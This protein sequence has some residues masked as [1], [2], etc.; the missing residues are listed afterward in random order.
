[1][2]RFILF[3]ISF[4]LALYVSAQ[5]TQTAKYDFVHP[6][7]LT[8]AIVMGDIYEIQVADKTFTVGPISLRLTSS[9]LKC[10]IRNT[11]EGCFLMIPRGTTITIKGNKVKLKSFS[12]G[13]K[14]QSGGLGL[15]K[16]QPGT[17]RFGEWSCDGKDDVT[18]VSLTNTSASDCII[19]T[20]DV[21]YVTPVDGLEPLTVSPADKATVITNEFNGVTFSFGTNISSADKEAFTFK[22]ITTGASIGA[23][24]AV[25]GKN[26]TVSPLE[27]L[28]A[29][30]YT[31]DV[32]SK[33]FKTA[34]GMYNKAFTTSFT[35]IDPQNMFNPTVVPD[36][37]V[38]K[39]PASFAI[40]FPSE[41]GNKGNSADPKDISKISVP[42]M[43][44]VTG[45]E[46][47]KASFS[48][49]S[50]EKNVLTVTLNP[51]TDITTNG[52]YK[53]SIPEKSVYNEHYGK[54]AVE[55]EL[56]NSEI[57]IEFQVGDVYVASEEILSE[58]SKALALSGLGYPSADAA[59][60]VALKK[61]YNEAKNE[62]KGSDDI[63]TA[64]INAF[65]ASKTVEM[66]LADNYY[67]LANMAK[68][69]TLRYLQYA[70]GKVT[71]NSSKEDAAHFKVTVTAE[72]KYVFSIYDAYLHTLMENN[73]YIGTSSNNVLTT[74]NAELNDLTV[75]RLLVE[76]VDNKTTIGKFSLYGAIGRAREGDPL[77]YGYSLV[78]DGAIDSQKNNKLWFDNNSS[79]AFVME[80]TTAPDPV[81]EYT[82]NPEDGANLDALNTI[83]ITIT[84][85]TKIQRNETKAIKLS[86]DMADITLDNYSIEGNKL[87]LKVSLT[88]DG[89]Y[90]LTVPK[91]AI[92]YTFEGR[93]VQVPE[94]KASYSV[95]FTEDFS[96]DFNMEY[97]IYT[98]MDGSVAHN[99]MDFK[100]AYIYSNMEFFVVPGM[101][102]FKFID[103]NTD[104]VVTKGTI[105]KENYLIETKTCDV[106][107]RGEEQWGVINRY[108]DSNR[109]NVIMTNSKGEIEYYT[110]NPVTDKVVTETVN[111]YEYRLRFIFPETMDFVN[112]KD[113]RYGFIIPKGSFGDRNYGKFLAG[114]A[115][116]RAD[117]HLNNI[118]EYYFESKQSAIPSG[119]ENIQ[120][121]ETEKSH[122]AVYDLLG[123]K[124]SSSLAPGIYIKNGKKFIVK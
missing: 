98:S 119:I 25:S 76:G 80:K 7:T 118:G 82:L 8:P 19:Y 4:V 88:K 2:R 106:I 26:V 18:S 17:F 78:T 71:L 70:D 22:N 44:T 103:Y 57:N 112:L 73:N 97:H 67:N 117:C 108:L 111:F 60:R 3:L 83:E 28:V 43:N 1:M 16:G 72:G 20:L 87:I 33:A 27:T 14:Y 105:E 69:G 81:T 10:S 41:I 34:S 86:S 104:K 42:V 107:Y 66:P 63:M 24:T 5:T 29:G 100:N 123:R 102:T 85:A 101:D 32:A 35:L 75:A 53:L 47:A 79:S 37:K 121:A 23:T 30:N 96:Y 65:Y 58:A 84:N 59:E 114:E 115:I 49:K 116:S 12:M 9:A 110:I 50:S 54:G 94:I 11:D 46:V 62:F 120:S 31:L 52:V 21:S 64:A 93:T 61:A 91:G 92:T 68:D 90:T 113:S 39:V 40:S 124:V 74:Y 36:G 15:D 38:E 56:W 13:E 51:A 55:G 95:V 109:K 99:P 6:E 45:S 122:D 89:N 77:S 48:V